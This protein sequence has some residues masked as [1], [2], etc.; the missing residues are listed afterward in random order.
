MPN[1][2]IGYARWSYSAAHGSVVIPNGPGDRPLLVDLTSLDT[3]SSMSFAASC[4]L[5]VS[6]GGRATASPVCIK[7]RRVCFGFLQIVAVFSRRN[8]LKASERCPC[9]TRDS[10]ML[11]VCSFGETAHL[12]IGVEACV[13]S[14]S[15]RL[16]MKS[17][18][19]RSI[20]DGLIAAH[21]PPS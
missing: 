16:L 11:W 5:S 18:R 4:C 14:A 13:W 9:R 20:K 2:A 7:S 19:F 3:S 8:T 12:E 21:G 10:A 1:T 6:A 17:L 15:H